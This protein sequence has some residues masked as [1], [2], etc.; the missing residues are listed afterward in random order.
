[1][2]RDAELT[3]RR[4]LRARVVRQIQFSNSRGVS[5]LFTSSRARREVDGLNLKWLAIIIANHR[6]LIRA[7]RWLLAIVQE[8]FCKNE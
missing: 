4:Q 3:Y 2:Q 7:T 1:M 8:Q 5:T 6:A